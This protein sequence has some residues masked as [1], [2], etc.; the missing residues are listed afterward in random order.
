MF[1]LRKTFSHSFTKIIKDIILAQQTKKESITIPMRLGMNS[2]LEYYPLILFAER[3]VLFTSS[4]YTSCLWLLA[5]Q[6]I[7]VIL[8]TYLLY[9]SRFCTFAL[10][11]F[12]LFFHPEEIQ[13]WP[14][15]D[16]FKVHLAKLHWKPLQRRRAEH[17]AIFIYK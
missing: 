8:K 17:C 15:S 1:S 6:T 9:D 13:L 11:L 16:Q 3:A 12:H 7:V 5:E 10:L 2:I 14:Q 4:V